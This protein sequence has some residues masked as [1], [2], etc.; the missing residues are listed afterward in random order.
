MKRINVAESDKMCDEV[1]KKQ[2]DKLK[3]VYLLQA[4]TSSFSLVLS[5]VFSD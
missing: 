3:L 5:S 1:I 4:I 2:I